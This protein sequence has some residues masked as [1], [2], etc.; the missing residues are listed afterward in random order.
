M[1]SRDV[2]LMRSIPLFSHFS[3]DQLRLI[4]FSA[5]PIEV[6]AGT[7][8]FRDGSRARGGYVVTAGEIRLT[9]SDPDQS[10]LDVGPG[11][12]IGELALF[13]PV[14][15]PATAVVVADARLIDISRDLLLRV[16]DEYPDM[17]KRLQKFLSS[18]LELLVRD[19]SVAERALLNADDFVFRSG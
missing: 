11:S 7:T 10:E 5:E 6:F 18:R 17:A 12:L 19:L 2:D 3:E 1:L 15:R 4:A 13:A 8:L 16:L 14:T 9:P